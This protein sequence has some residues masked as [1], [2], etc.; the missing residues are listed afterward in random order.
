[1]GTAPTTE[2]FEDSPH[3]DVP[4]VQQRERLSPSIPVCQDGPWT[5]QQLPA[6]SAPFAV[7]PLSTTTAHI[8]GA[9]LRRKR[10][11]L[12]CDQDWLVSRSS[13]AQQVPWYAKVPLVLESCDAIYAR[14]ASSTANLTV[15]PEN[16]AD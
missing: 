13:S 10:V 7:V 9:D 1:M 2:V 14:V 11:V 16:W 4:E 15:I 5:T 6:R 12:I 8:L 3:P